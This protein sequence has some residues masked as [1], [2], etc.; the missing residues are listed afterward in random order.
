VQRDS[1]IKGRVFYDATAVAGTQK[2]SADGMKIDKNGNIFSAGPGG[3][4]VFDRKGKLLGKFRIPEAVSN[5]SL[6][7]D[8]KTL[9]V[10]ADMYVLR[11]KLR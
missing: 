7:R 9:Y 3:L 1:L 2:G 8:Q 4:W 11:I 5:C 6:S 10:T